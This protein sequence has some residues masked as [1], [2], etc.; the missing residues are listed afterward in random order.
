MKGYKITDGQRSKLVGIACNSLQE[1]RRKSYQKLGITEDCIVALE[2]GTVVD[3][4]DYFRVIPNQSVL[5]FYR[6]NEKIK[7]GNLFSLLVY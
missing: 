6:K 2:D 5:V 3:D 4:E 1:L 7:T